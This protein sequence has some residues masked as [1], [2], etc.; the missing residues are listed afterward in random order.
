MILFYVVVFKVMFKDNDK[1]LSGWI[2]D[3]YCDFDGAQLVF[4]PND[5]SNFECP[6]CHYQYH[7]DKKRRAWVT[8]YRYQIF[9]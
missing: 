3:Y 7:D 9:S 5:S 8:K 1:W 2:H 4:D 6:I